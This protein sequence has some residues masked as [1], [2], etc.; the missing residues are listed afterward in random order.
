MAST[1]PQAET[2]KALLEDVKS[3]QGSWSVLCESWQRR[4]VRKGFTGK[5]SL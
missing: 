1:V 3:A 5:L 4:H 2:S